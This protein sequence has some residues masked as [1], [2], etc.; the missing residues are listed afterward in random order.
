MKRKKQTDSFQ[1]KDNE[2]NIY[3]II[4]F[5]NSEQIEQ[6]GEELQSIDLLKYY[7][8]EKNETVNRTGDTYIILTFE[9]EIST[10]RI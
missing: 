2:G 3:T 4:E 1:T 5:T 7:R 9:G 10:I 6:F 8:T